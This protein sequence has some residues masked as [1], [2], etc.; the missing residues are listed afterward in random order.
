MN[1]KAS[2]REKICY[3]VGNIGFGAVY[4]LV[5][6]YIM[7]Y[8]TDVAAIGVLAAGTIMT[9][10]RVVDAITDPIMGT[11]VDKTNTKWGKARPYLLF[12]AIPLAVITFLMFSTPNLSGNG[13]FVYA[14]VIYLG[15]SVIYT[16]I[17]IHYST[18]LPLMT[19]RQD[20]R[21]TFG[22]FRSIAS[23]IGG[24]LVSGFV[25]AMVAYFGGGDEGKGFSRTSII[26]G[27]FAVL[28]LVICFKNTKERIQLGKKNEKVSVIKGLKV[29]VK[30][31]YW[32]LVICM[33]F[34]SHLTAIMQSQSTMYYC[35]YALNNMG[36][37]AGLLSIPKLV[38]IPAALCIP[39]VANKIGPKN[40]VLIGSLLRAGASVGFYFVGDSVAGLYVMRTIAAVGTSTTMCL[41]Y[42]LCAETIDYT[43]WKTGERPNG[44]MTSITGFMIK[45]G[46]TMAGLL[47]SISLSIGGYV[48]NAEQSASAMRAISANFIWMPAVFPAIIAILILFYDLDKN[49]REKIQEELRVRRAQA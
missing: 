25:L 44:I 42:V 39:V 49:K 21:L 24:F 18:M 23:N 31:K 6:S 41:I 43:E 30:N 17:D 12:M 16:M 1:E 32:I 8:Y 28:C 27:V 38:A 34:L 35:K 15:Y 20:D 5:S 33:A 45:M 2:M 10:A 29:A 11:I 9:A 19:D 22:T 46:L 14:M 48:E 37:A 40:C 13:K 7:Y 47:S 36:L 3:G 4:A 26:F